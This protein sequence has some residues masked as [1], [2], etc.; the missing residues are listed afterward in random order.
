M[1]K[2]TKQNVDTK[3]KKC[4]RDPT[5]YKSMPREQKMVRKYLLQKKAK[6]MYPDKRFSHPFTDMV[7]MDLT[8]LC[9]EIVTKGIIVSDHE[10][11]TTFT[12][13]H[14]ELVMKLQNAKIIPRKYRKKV[15]SKKNML[16]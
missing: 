5:F 14:I 2:T 1:T 6:N 16:Q 10:K 4:N 8:Y 15:S 3:P 11:H 13:K 7:L 9:D 12:D